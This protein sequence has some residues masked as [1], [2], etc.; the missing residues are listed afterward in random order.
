MAAADGCY[1]NGMGTQCAPAGMIAGEA[2][3][4]PMMPNSCQEGYICVA[5]GSSTT[6]GVCRHLC[7]D[8]GRTAGCPTGQTCAV[9]FTDSMMRGS[10]I[11]FCALPASCDL[12]TQMG[13]PDGDGCY[14]NGSIDE[15]NVICVSPTDDML[16]EGD[17]CSMCGASPC[18]GNSCLPG[19]GCFQLTMGMTTV[20]QC[21]KFC[22]TATMMGCMD[23]QTCM[24]LMSGGLPDIGICTPA[25]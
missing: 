17:D 12:V 24:S 25:M 5:E 19:T 21:F 2:M 22:N 15:G 1:F 7:C 18:V 6:M 3:C 9:Q 13:C 16:M 4:N 8:I 20:E 10:G 14:L 23:G 11:G